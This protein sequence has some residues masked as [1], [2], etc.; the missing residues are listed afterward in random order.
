[1]S[2]WAPLSPRLVL[3]LFFKLTALLPEN[4]SVSVCLLSETRFCSPHR[5]LAVT[6][7]CVEPHFGGNMIVEYGEDGTGD[8]S[9]QPAVIFSD[10]QPL[11]CSEHP[12]SFS[13]RTPP[14]A[15]RNSFYIVQLK[16]TCLQ[17]RDC[18]NSSLHPK[19]TLDFILNV[20]CT[21]CWCL[22]PK[23]GTEVTHG[24]DEYF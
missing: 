11:K 21:W 19:G 3:I 23:H 5:S 16:Q 17:H 18:C 1:M 4:K 12:A 10:V 14:H 15:A 20:F 9:I 22:T 13:R 2:H 8:C 7:N 24:G 6:L